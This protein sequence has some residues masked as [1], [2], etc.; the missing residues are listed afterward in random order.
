MLKAGYRFLAFRLLVPHG[1]AMV[2]GL[3][4]KFT[5]LKDGAEN[6]HFAASMARSRLEQVELERADFMSYILKR[7]F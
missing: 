5:A 6:K 4:L 2:A 1:I 7:V 3:A